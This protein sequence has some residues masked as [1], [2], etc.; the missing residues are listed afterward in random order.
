MLF[1][2]QYRTLKFDFI[3]NNQ[4]LALCIDRLREFGGDGM[5]S[6]L[7]LDDETFVTNNTTEDMW[8]LNGPIADVGPLFL[9]TL[10]LFL[11]GMRWLP[12]CVPIIS[13][14]L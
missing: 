10:F 14:L 9:S 2:T 7:V 13:E 3:L 6:G 1:N 5:M 11:F 12:P 8:F 4:W